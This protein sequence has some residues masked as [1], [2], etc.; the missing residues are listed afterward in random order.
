MQIVCL[1]FYRFILK[2]R[3]CALLLLGVVHSV[4]LSRTCVYLLMQIASVFFFKA[5]FIWIIPINENSVLVSIT[6]RVGL[7]ISLSDVTTQIFQFD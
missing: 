6:F 4:N 2:V 3:L 5:K 1:Y 7:I